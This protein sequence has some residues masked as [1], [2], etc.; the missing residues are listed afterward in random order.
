ME[1]S[2]NINLSFATAAII[3]MLVLTVL[4]ILFFVAY[5]RRLLKEQNARQAER[6]A[7][8][9]ELLR[10]SLESQEREQSRMAAELHDGAG[11][12]LST[13]RLYLQQLRLQ[14][15]STQAKD[16]LKMA[17]NMLRDTVTTIRTISQNLQPAELESIGLV[18]AVR[19]LTDTLEKTGAV[20]VH[21][22]LHPTPEL[23]PEAQL[24]LY[25][26][27]QELINNAIKH[28]QARTL[29]VRLTADE[30]AVRL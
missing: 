26:M 12:M 18:G 19:T 24:L 20:Q 4:L 9:K 15:D 1:S 11:A 29:T 23:G 30:A 21:T 5:Q 10:A 3:G 22:D 25:R 17:E 13:T 6:E 16:W 28:A 27:A 2:E 8:Q 7:H 14:P